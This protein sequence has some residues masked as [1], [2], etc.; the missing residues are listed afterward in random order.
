VTRS[1]GRVVVIDG[2]WATLTIDPDDPENDGQLV[3]FQ[4]TLPYAN[5]LS[6]R[7]LRQL[8]AHHGLQ[9]IEID[10]QPVFERNADV[11]W[12]WQQSRTL[13]S[14]LEGRFSSANVVLISGRKP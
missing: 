7:C 5:P 12:C 1:G 9:D 10:V 4:Q 2:D 14:E 13:L 6:G 11:A 3:Y 8:F